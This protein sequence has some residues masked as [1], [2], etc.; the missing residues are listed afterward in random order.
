M[1]SSAVPITS[2]LPEAAPVGVPK[3]RLPSGDRIPVLD[4]IRGIAILLVMTFHFWMLGVSDAAPAWE[5]VYGDVVGIGWIGVDLFFVLSGFLITGILYD[6]R[7]GAHYFRVFYGRRTLRI[8]PLYY[9]ALTIFFLIG[10]F[11]LAHV[12]GPVLAGMNSGNV[13]KVF[14][15]TYLLNWYE[16]FK[17]WYAVSRPLQHFWSL[18]VEEQFYLIWPLLVLKLERRRLMGVCAGLMVLA[19]TLRV[20]TYWLHFPFAAYTWTICRADSLAI[21]AI[22]ALAARDS[23]DWKKLLKWARRLALPTL[24]AIILGRILNP[25]CTAGPGDSPTFFMNTFELSLAGIFFGACIAL[26]V[27]LRRESLGH[28]LLASPFLRFF[29]KYSY[30]LYVCHMPIMVVS[31]KMGLNCRHLVRLLHSELL[32]VLAVNGIAFALSIAVA[33]ASWH[34]YEKQWL[35]LKNVRGLQRPEQVSTQLAVAD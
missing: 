23:G 5:R 13:D 31:A 15:W 14:A 11:V 8:F 21:G 4:G 32:S 27:A 9:A 16:G 10:P 3:K 22:V 33:F 24:G 25:T 6:S 34:L 17:G 26:A 28:R 12:H 29:G 18:A 19:L 7:E 35:K 1:S 30:C 20:V 2:D